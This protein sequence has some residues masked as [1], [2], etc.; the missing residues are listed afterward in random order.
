M[1]RVGVVG[2]DALSVLDFGAKAD[3]RT[4]DSAAIQRAVDAAQTQNLPLLLPAGVYLL[5]SPVVVRADVKPKVA[6]VSG[7]SR[8]AARR[9]AR[10]LASWR[11]CPLYSTDKSLYL[12]SH[13]SAIRSTDSLTCTHRRSTSSAAQV[14]SPLR[15]LGDGIEDP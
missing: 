15:M 3:G 10:Q 12:A 13:L 1:A 5:A 7:T 4:D 8:R 14:Y 11:L 9:A 2:D 6:A